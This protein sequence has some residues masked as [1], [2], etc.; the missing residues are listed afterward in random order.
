M[1]DTVKCSCSHCGAK[2]RLPVEA[3]GRAARC[4]RCGEKFVV[5]RELSLEDSILTWLSVPEETEDTA[6]PPKI[7]SMP[8]ADA[9]HPNEGT[10]AGKRIRG[11]IRLKTSVPKEESA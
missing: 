2:Y 5:P 1:P 8:G 11:T 3:Q 7:I 9:E 6:P 4:K 10:V